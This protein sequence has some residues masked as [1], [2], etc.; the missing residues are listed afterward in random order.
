MMSNWFQYQSLNLKKTP[1]IN[2]HSELWDAL[3]EIFKTVITW[4]KQINFQM[5]SI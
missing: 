3:F 4:E 5:T 2:P 1:L